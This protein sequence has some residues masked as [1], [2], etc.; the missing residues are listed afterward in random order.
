MSNSASFN[1]YDYYALL[2]FALTAVASIALQN[3]IW[4]SITLFLFYS[5][6][7]SKKIVWPRNLFTAATLLFLATYFIGA[8][9]GINP[10]KSF[11]TVHKT[12]TFLLIFP[13]GAMALSIA[14]IRKL[15]DYFITGATFCALF[16]IGKHFLLHQDRI[17][18]FSGDKM[19]F[20]GMLMVTVL[21]ITSLLTVNP[22]NYWLWASLGVV[23]LALILTQTRGAWLGV[24][25]GFI[26]LTWRFNKKWLWFGLALFVISFLVAPQE[27]QK[28][29]ESIGSV[30]LVY[31]EKHE[32][33]GANQPR[34]LIWIAG[35]RIIKDHPMG[36]GQGNIEDIYPQY[37][38]DA[39]GND[40]DVPHL[41]DNFLQ[42]LAQN[43]WLGLVSYLFW[44]FAFYWETLH[45]RPSSEEAGL[46]NWMLLC[47][48]SS[49]L[50]WGLTE[51]TFSHQFMNIQFFFMGMVVLLWEKH[52]KKISQV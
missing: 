12:L 17:D 31:N 32:V 29:L 26:L 40:T 15:L 7:Y 24:L 11:Q 35:L 51:Y 27:F 5:F 10:A 25:V 47:V 28:R 19:V 18:S 44:I 34:P 49:I 6:K 48:F 1:R 41:H 20:G 23:F 8:I 52:S 45:F 50:V 39:P 13:L 30:H 38:I 42:I 46:W 36:V 2:A 21:L 4:V 43:G 22:K 16:G 33:I 37:R 14:D 3:F 9:V